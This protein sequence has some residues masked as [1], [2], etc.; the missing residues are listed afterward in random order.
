MDIIDDWIGWGYVNEIEWRN[1][2]QLQAR[3]DVEHF[4]ER[5]RRGECATW[6]HSE[7]E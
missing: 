2:D 7:P 1:L 4:V 6:P 3:R 5:A